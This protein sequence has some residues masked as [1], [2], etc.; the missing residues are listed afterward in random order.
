MPHSIPIN[1]QQL[2]MEYDHLPAT[3]YIWVIVA[4]NSSNIEERKGKKMF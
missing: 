1:P 4:Y 2:A 3:N